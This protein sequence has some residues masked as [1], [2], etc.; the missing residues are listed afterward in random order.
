MTHCV[1]K[2]LAVSDLSP[3]CSSISSTSWWVALTIFWTFSIN[4]SLSLHTFSSSSMATKFFICLFRNST[5]CW[6]FEMII[7]ESRTRSSASF[8]SLQYLFDFF[9]RVTFSSLDSFNSFWAICSS[10]QLLSN[11]CWR[12]SESISAL[13]AMSKKILIN[14]LDVV[15]CRQV[16]HDFF[17]LNSKNTHFRRWIDKKRCLDRKVMLPKPLIYTS[18]VKRMSTLWSHNNITVTK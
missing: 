18:V 2:D 11:F 7:S 4:L 13:N 17:D 5:L 12:S 1:L 16:G 10:K 3:Y 14:L 15:L 6:R 8:F 9:L